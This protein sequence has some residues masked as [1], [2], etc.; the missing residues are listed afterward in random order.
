MLH[1]EVEIEDMRYNERGNYWSYLCPCGDLFIFTRQQY[2]D[3][4]EYAKC[5]SC[6]L[7]IK[8]IY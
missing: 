7:V 6:P 8:I 5:P 4:E 2:E 3:G 1:D